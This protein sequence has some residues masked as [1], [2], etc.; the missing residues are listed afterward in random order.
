MGGT[1]QHVT[2]QAGERLVLYDIV[3]VDIQ[4]SLGY[5][6]LDAVSFHRGEDQQQNDGGE[7]RPQHRPAALAR[8]QRHIQAGGVPGVLGTAMSEFNRH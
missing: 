1:Q 7:T 5:R 8:R 6:T 2:A 3:A 4:V